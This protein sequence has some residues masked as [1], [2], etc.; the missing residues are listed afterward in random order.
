[1]SPWGEKG[2][3]QRTY[4]AEVAQRLRRIHQVMQTAEEHNNEVT[5]R[6]EDNKRGRPQ[7][8]VGDEVLCRYF[9]Q[10]F[11]MTPKKQNFSYHGP[12]VITRV[13][14]NGSAMELRGLPAGMPTV[15]N[16]EYLRAYR[17]CEEAAELAAQAPPPAA[18]RD[19]EGELTWEVEEILAHR[20][21]ANRLEYQVKWR[22]YPETTWNAQ[23]DL[24]DCA[25]LLG[26]YWEQRGGASPPSSASGRT[27]RPERRRRRGGL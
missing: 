22:G 16:V 15:I 19:E 6:R 21:R 18:E 8:Q 4:A 27:S 13:A 11:G 23:K 5:K 7:F 2:R 12:Y 17:R 3:R 24:Q 10:S 1:M 26:K 14:S 25:E 9:P 20:W